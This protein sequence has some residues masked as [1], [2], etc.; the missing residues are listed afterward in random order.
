MPS[1]ITSIGGQ[2]IIEGV[3]MR[4]PH[5]YAAAVRTKDGEIVVEK[6]P[7]NS[8][9]SKYKLLKIYIVRGM[10]SF[11]ESIVM[12]MKSLMFSAD[13]FDIDEEQTEFDKWIDKKFGEKA[14]TFTIYFSVVLALLMSI[15]LFIIIPTFL[16]GLFFTNEGSERILFN[17]VEGIFKIAIFMGYIILIS[18][19]DDIKRVFEYHG[20]EH[21]TI[22][23]Y[24]AGEELN[25]ENVK[26][27][28][29]LHPRCG[30]SFLLLVIVLTIFVFSIFPSP[31]VW[32]AILHRIIL[33]PLVAGISYEI[34][35][36]VGKSE[37]KFV[38]I[39]NKPGMWF[40][41]FTTREPDDKQIMVAI[42]ALKSV[43]PENED[44][45]K[46]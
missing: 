39:F 26:K 14:K 1:K 42:E 7:V 44:E 6:H 40:Q 41:N 28:S 27:Y 19:M 30:T 24:E 12:G 38:C 4:G 18:K 8:V 35:K 45:A 34:I 3:M 32:W 13:F 5:E 46:W 11:F 37:N 17:A 2:A 25:V 23:C 10:V 16:A 29:R 36:F 20:A 31:N 9:I 22:H 21:K 43:M 33:L 15:G